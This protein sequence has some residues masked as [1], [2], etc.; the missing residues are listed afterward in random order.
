MFGT[1]AGSLIFDTRTDTSGFQRGTKDIGKQ[2]EQ[3]SKS[4]KRLSKVIVATFSIAVIKEFGTQLI[5]TT[6][7]LKAL[8][9][10]FEQIFKGEEGVDAMKLI[11]EQ[12]DELGIHADRL[13]ASFSQFGAQLKGAGMDA[14]QALEGTTNATK[15]A[16]DAA[17]FYDVSLETSSASLASFLKGNFEAGD[18]IGVYTNAT[19]MGTSAQKMYGKSWDKLTEAEKQWLLLDK[20]SQVYELNGAAGQA[21]REQ[22]NWANVTENLKSTWGRFL[23][24]VGTPVL[25]TVVEIVKNITDAISELTNFMKDNTATIDTFKLAIEAL[26]VALTAYF[27]IVSRW[28]ILQ[29]LIG[30]TVQLEVAM[31]TFGA[32]L[33]SPIGQMSIAIGVLVIF[34]GLLAKLSG[35]W[36]SMSGYEK[37]VSVLG[38]VA[39]AAAGAA[40]A[41][42]AL[43]SAATL[44]IAAVAI[45]GGVLA[46]TAAINSAQKKAKA[47]VKSPS[48]GYRL[49]HLA[50]GAV[51]PANGE[52]MAV[53]GDQKYGKNLEAPEGLIRKIIREEV[54]KFGG[55][56]GATTVILQ[57]DGRELARTTAPYN[58]GET[59]RL[60]TR[61]INGVT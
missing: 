16:A 20:V 19:Q 30:V 47:G 15:L 24:L 35:A 23:E 25:K 50:S 22:D 40:A 43:Q 46:I 34:I 14:T 12:A 32:A 18:A 42:G 51:I 61:L 27:V 31:K 28:T 5:E 9:A 17:A 52:F 57:V 11:N 4:F 13:K 1:V 59:N 7:D 49:P 45:V 60:G 33:M 38:I 58:T 8:D 39:I 2:T 37:A 10:Q 55:S 3:L 54:P 56:S 26:A 36:D 29:K 41:I 53:L 48:G 6:A 21:A 44:G